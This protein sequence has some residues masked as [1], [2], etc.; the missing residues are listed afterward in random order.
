MR[1][2]EKVLEAF[3]R[4]FPGAPIY[5]LF[6][7]EG[8]LSATIEAHPIHTSAL[9]RVP[10]AIGHYRAWLPSFPAVIEWFDLDHVDLIVST[11]HCAAKSVV[12]TGRARHLC[13]CHSPM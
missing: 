7:A 8:R 5:T 6:H 3:C 11:S 2:G 13:Y 12:R 9:Q 4:I 10:G 1:G